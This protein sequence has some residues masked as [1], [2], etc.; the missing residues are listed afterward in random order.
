VKIY[1]GFNSGGDT[2]SAHLV[3]IESDDG[4]IEPT[5]LEHHVRH[6]PGGLSWGYRGSGPADL[7]RSIL[8]DYLGEEPH[9]AC[10]QAFKDAFVAGWPQDD[11]WVL[12]GAEL[13]DWLERWE[14]D[15]PESFATMS[16][17]HTYLEG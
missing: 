17:Y 16:S 3:T 11:G 15:Y 4:D 2:S 10:Y 14:G 7:A 1:R 13:A 5:L 6:S 8:W 9:P 12:E